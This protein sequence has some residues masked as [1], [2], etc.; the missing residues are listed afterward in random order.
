MTTHDVRED[1]FP[2]P[3]RHASGLVNGITTDV[4]SLSFSDK[5]L[6]T[7]SQEGRL[8][9]WVRHSV[10]FALATRREADMEF[11]VPLTGSSGGIVDMTLPS[12]NHGLLPS[13]HLTPRTLVGGGGDDRETFGQLYAAQIASRLSLKSPDDRRILVLGLG[14]AKFETEREAFFDL[15]E[16]AQKVL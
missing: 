6:V 10:L 9:Q 7:I 11:Q 15:F 1:E 13:T 3:S 4:T 16:L 5:I 14:L 8:S 2:V 12:L